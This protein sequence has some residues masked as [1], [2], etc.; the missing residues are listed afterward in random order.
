VI[1]NIGAIL[2]SISFGLFSERLG[3]RFA[4]IAS[5]ALALLVIPAWAFGGSAVVLIAGAFLMQ[6]GVQGAWGIVPVHLTEMVPDE[7]RGLLSG[8][9]YQLGTLF[10]A[11][12]PRTE[13]ALRARYGYQWAIA[14]FE[15]FTILSLI[16]I[17]SLGKERKGRSFHRAA[18]VPVST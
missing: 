5:M 13:Y 10:G 1:Y 9:A 15:V 4:M 7:T 14:G 16:L 3:R 6:F 11:P 17:L 8:L 12:A 2:G 18:E